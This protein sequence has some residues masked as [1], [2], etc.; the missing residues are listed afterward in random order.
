MDILCKYGHIYCTKYLRQRDLAEKI[1][2]MTSYKTIS[3][4][5]RNL[6]INRTFD[7]LIVRTSY[8]RFYSFLLVSTRFYSFLPKYAALRDIVS[9]SLLF[10]KFAY[11]KKTGRYSWE[12]K[13]ALNPSSYVGWALS[14]SND[15]NLDCVYVSPS[16]YWQV[17]HCGNH[18]DFICERDYERDYE[19][20]NDFY[21][22]CSP[23]WSTM[24]KRQSL[25]NLVKRKKK[26]VEWCYLFVICTIDMMSY[27]EKYGIKDFDNNYCTLGEG[28]DYTLKVYFHEE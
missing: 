5:K 22:L 13:K 17:D 24:Y 3:S 23:F 8:L 20:G 15:M 12:D 28:S 25:I 4:C 11:K 9:T 19:T 7:I 10:L 27:C 18:K 14:P 1:L 26:P 21:L 6:I 2:S 16:S